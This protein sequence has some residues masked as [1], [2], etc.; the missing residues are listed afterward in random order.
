MRL[1]AHGQGFLAFFPPYR[2]IEPFHPKLSF[3]DGPFPI[4]GGA[5]VWNMTDGYHQG[6]FKLVRNRPPGVALIVILPP[7]AALG[8]ST[9]LFEM[10]TGCRP[11]SVLPHQHEIDTDELV[12]VLR[13]TPSELAIEVSDYLSWRG[14]HVDLDTRRLIRKTLD[15]SGELRTVGGLARGLYMSRRALGRRFL[16]RG[17]PVPSHWLHFGRILRAAILLQDPDR[18]VTSAARALGYPDAFAL[19]NQMKRLTGLRPSIMKEC[20]GWEWIVEAWLRVEVA[21]EDLP[22]AVRDTLSPW[23]ARLPQGGAGQTQQRALPLHRSLRVG[24]SHP[25]SSREGA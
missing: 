19:S 22:R 14:L 13:R 7:A 6:G 15:L 25:R 2:T 4:R 1:P 18:T 17:L 11:H 21:Q 20:F 8:D 16:T 3:P 9:I 5:V 23:I 12:A 24:E 10:M